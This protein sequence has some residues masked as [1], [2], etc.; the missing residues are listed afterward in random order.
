[1]EYVEERHCE[2]VQTTSVLLSSVGDNVVAIAISCTRD[3]VDHDLLT[4]IWGV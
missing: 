4:S 1:M 2:C 3:C